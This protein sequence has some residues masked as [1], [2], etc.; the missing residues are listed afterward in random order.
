MRTEAGTGKSHVLAA[1][2][3]AAVEAADIADL[4]G[5]SGTSVRRRLT[6]INSGRCSS[7]ARRRDGPDIWL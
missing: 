6:G 1:L 2:G 4:Y 3:V 5:H 7:R